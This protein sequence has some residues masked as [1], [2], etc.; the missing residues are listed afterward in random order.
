[1][2]I[3]DTKWE[4]INFKGEGPITNISKL[5]FNLSQFTF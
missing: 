3:F 4:N 2:M 1:M 5:T